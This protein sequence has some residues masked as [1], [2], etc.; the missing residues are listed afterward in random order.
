MAK[1]D[2]LDASPSLVHERLR[3]QTPLALAF[4]GQDVTSWQRKLRRKLRQLLGFD[5]MPR[6][7]GPLRPRTVW[8]RKHELGS[9]EKLVFT[10][11]P[12]ADVPAYLCLPAQPVSDPPPVFICLQGHSTGM[13]NSIAV[14]AATES[15]PIEVAGDRDFAIGAMRHG[16]AALCI[17]QRAFAQRRERHYGQVGSHITCQQTT[18]NALLLGR[19]TMGERIFDVQ[20]AIA[21]LDQLRRQRKL[22]VDM[23]RLGVMGNSGGGTISL[24]GAAL[25]TR[26]RFVMP[27]CYFC[28]FH[29]SIFKIHHCVDNY[30]P[31][32]LRWAEMPDVAGL[33]AP[34]PVVMVAGRTD[35]IFPIAGV[36]RAFRRLKTIYE[37]AGAGDRCQLVVGPEGHRFY[38]DLA[39]P[40]MLRH[41]RS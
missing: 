40:K 39:W 26:L 32:I 3:R 27:S 22:P 31:G 15:K 33:I 41:L 18:M 19:T 23:K 20:R 10:S 1:S 24:F 5:Q 7:P 13:H 21:L 35:E 6:D 4:D 30:V 11:E 12:G 8:R 34:R 38:A 29:D 9:I 28:T 25:L 14:D 16:L 37:A 36:R 2:V 17:E